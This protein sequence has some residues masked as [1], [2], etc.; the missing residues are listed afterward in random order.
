[1]SGDPQ[2]ILL[3]EMCSQRIEVVTSLAE[4][5]LF[6]C[7][8]QEMY[9]DHQDN[10]PSGNVFPKDPGSHFISVGHP[11]PPLP[12]GNMSED[13]QDK[14]PSGDVFPKDPLH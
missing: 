5:L 14:F 8:L 6:F 12:P 1:M 11:I 2:V 3:L 7:P 4:G 10:F 9:G 13:P